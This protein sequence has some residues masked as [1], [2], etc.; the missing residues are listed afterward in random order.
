VHRSIPLS[1]EQIR[2]LEERASRVHRGLLDTIRKVSQ[3]LGCRAFLIGGVPRDLILCRGLGDL[4]LVVEGEGG[5]FA[6][7]LA[8][9]LG[10]TVKVH[11]R[12]GTAAVEG[13]GERLD[14]ASTRR[15]RY[16]SPAAL[17]TIQ[18]GLL[19]DD[20]RRRDFTVNTLVIE[21]GK[22]P[23]FEIQDAFGG[24]EDLKEG[25]L[26]VLHRGSF[27]DDPTRVL[28]GVRFE[29]RLGLRLDEEAERLA[30]S[31][32][33]GGVFEAL[34]GD[35]LRRELFRLL[36]PG[37]SLRERLHR[38]QELGILSILHPNLS[39]AQ[40]DLDWI[41]RAATAWD[42]LPPDLSATEA[43]G[44]PLSLLVGSLDP[45]ERVEMLD[46]LA[47]RPSE[48]AW[49]SGSMEALG[50]AVEVLGRQDVKPHEVD[51]VLR[52]MKG[53]Q[54]ALLLAFTG[55][56]VV[57]WTQR[58]IDELRGVKVSLTGQELIEGGLSPGPEIGR[59]L[60]ATREARLDGVIS[61]KDELDY[62]LNV[63]KS[64]SHEVV[65]E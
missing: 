56:P 29:T 30:R 47:V 1:S 9:I 17:P 24:S 49:L 15:E 3:E 61:R 31:A 28:R 27:E 8:E 54:I 64:S 52:A 65:G 51:R 46:R 18:P 50:H 13:L 38:L 59:A 36:A 44:L 21:V 57:Q 5:K 58:W 20:L 2:L 7:R 22:G 60:E 4:D 34:S 6:T 62:A 43:W 55:K 12:F 37:A 23:P 45:G 33:A 19:A 32:V 39:L 53:E 40:R 11:S 26:R 14:V 42:S 48:Q 16:E 41:D 10:G 25:Y 63:S 35:R